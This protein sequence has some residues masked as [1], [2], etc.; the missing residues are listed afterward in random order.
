MTI[1]VTGGAGYIGSHFIRRFLAGMDE[2]VIA[3][4]NLSTGNVKALVQDERVVHFPIDISDQRALSEIIKNHT[5]DTVVHFAASCYVGESEQDPFKYFNNN[6]VNTL[7][8]LNC[9][10]ECKVR[11]LV[12]S[13]SCA[14]YG[15]PEKLPLTEDHKR[16]PI[17]VYGQTKMIVEQILEGLHRT[18]ELSYIALRYFNAAGADESGQI[19]ESHDPETHLIPNALKALKGDTTHVEIYGNDYDTKDGTCIRDYI[20]VN[21]LANAHIAAVQLLRT[22]RCGM[23]IN[24]GTGI[25]ASVQEVVDICSKVAGRQLTTKILPRRE[26]DPPVL[27]ADYE[28][29]SKVLSWIPS[30]SLEK[31]IETAWNWQMNRKY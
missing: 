18:T 5:P 9:L 8:L 24:L 6:V 28:K 17:N 19:G 22:E 21:D 3:V 13:S 2:K 16:A 23:G 25:G 15:K 1:L 11:N 26:G 7:A 31:I 12:F 30:Y 14:I 10:E 4:D 27:V 29:A 20:H